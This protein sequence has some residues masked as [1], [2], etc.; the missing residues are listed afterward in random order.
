MVQLRLHQDVQRSMGPDEILAKVRST[1]YLPDLQRFD[2]VSENEENIF[3]YRKAK[4]TKSEGNRFR[5]EYLGSGNIYLNRNR[6]VILH[7]SFIV[8]E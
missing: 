7:S 2:R 8:L 3:L 6:F 5:E 4:C 1:T